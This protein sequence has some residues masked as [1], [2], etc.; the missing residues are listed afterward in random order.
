MLT[1]IGCGNL[2]RRDDG[3]G[4]IVAQRLMDRLRAQPVPGVQAFDCGTAGFE[5]MRRA[6]GSRALC[7]VDASQSGAPAGSIHE[8]SGDALATR[9]LPQVNLHEFRWDYALAVGRAL[10]KDEFPKDVRVILVEA[11][12]L[13][14]GEGLSP[15]VVQAADQ[16]YKRL[17]DLCASCTSAR[18]SSVGGAEHTLFAQRGSLH[19]PRELFETLFAEHGTA[20]VWS[21]PESGEIVIVPVV[22][23]DGGVRVKQQNAHGDRAVD[24]REALRNHGWD[25]TGSLALQARV[26]GSLGA[27]V[28]K[29]AQP[30]QGNPPT[31]Q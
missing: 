31:R 21:R 20:A 17:L 3:V 13:G 22:P 16:V 18:A 26:D 1:V 7:V 23:E 29:P 9:E 24:I 30:S 8:L 15:Q 10:Y 6:R 27:L 4:V 14:H 25:D 19:M 12:E 2:M 28:L 5:V 11:A